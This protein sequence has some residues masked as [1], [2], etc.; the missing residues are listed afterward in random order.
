MTNIN[1]KKYKNVPNVIRGTNHFGGIVLGE[2]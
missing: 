2:I 1:I